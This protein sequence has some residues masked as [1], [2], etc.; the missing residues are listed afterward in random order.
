MTLHKLQGP[1]E[2]TIQQVEHIS[3]A[4]CCGVFVLGDIDEHGALVAKYI[5][6][7]N[8]NIGKR[9]GD[10][11]DKYPYFKIMRCKKPYDAFEKQCKI[12][13]ECSLFS[14]LDNP[15]HPTHPEEESWIC[16]VCG[17]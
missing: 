2:L 13:H 15:M 9:L 14:K 1:Y 6:M 8:K 10:F 3:S 12:Y 7:A 16:P 4:P 17:K 5:G 11:I